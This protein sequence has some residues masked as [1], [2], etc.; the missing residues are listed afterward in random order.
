MAH[1]QRR[2]LSSLGPLPSAGFRFPLGRLNDQLE[3]GT[4]RFVVVF[5][6]TPMKLEI[7]RFPPLIAARVIG[8]L[9][10]VAALVLML[11]GWLFTVPV[12]GALGFHGMPAGVA[13]LIVT[14]G[15][16]LSAYAGAAAFCAL[17]NVLAG[18]FGGIIVETRRVPSDRAE[19]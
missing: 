6:G 3:R 4:E 1:A 10:G 13:A 16:W 18:R 15:W 14:I 5:P 19:P 9:F 2:A 7:R 11:V 17:Y 12:P 8:A